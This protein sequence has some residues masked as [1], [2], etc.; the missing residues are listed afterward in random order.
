MP[1]ME[2]VLS[3]SREIY[4]PLG[5]QYR[6]GIRTWIMP[7][8]ARLKLRFLENDADASKYQGH[9][10][11]WIGL[12]ELGSW[13]S[14]DPVDKLRATLRSAKGVTCRM[15]STA[16]PG[17]LGHAWINERYIKPAPP[18]T[19]FYDADR[20]TWRVFIPSRLQD[21]KILL[22]N[23]PTYIDRLKS[24]G[25]SWLV[26]AWLE[27]DWTAAQEGNIFLREMWQYY[28][29]VPIIE[30]IVHSWDCAF[31]TG[32]ENDF[33]VCTIWAVCKTGYYLLHRWKDK[34]EF[35][36]LKR[37]AIQLANQIPPNQILIEDKASGQSLIQELQRETRLSITPYKVDRDKIARAH[38]ASPTV[39]AGK[40]YL[41]EG[42]PWVMDYVDE[43]AAFP[44]ALHDDDVDSTT[45][46]LL[47]EL[48]GANMFAYDSV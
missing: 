15:I 43:M 17:G 28:K 5:C 12:D 18:M 6:A 45:Q 31:K 30:R 24:S 46:F 11:T 47:N 38:A 41:P 39:E 2:D 32:E 19:P 14:P 13:P 16:N 22:D 1:E 37:V 36:E 21:N 34:V 23:D 40:V 20:H 48:S 3:R 8:E 25:P 27:G 35:P 26:K 44:K 4:N 29:V 33:S 42:E 7:N 10:Y 9:S